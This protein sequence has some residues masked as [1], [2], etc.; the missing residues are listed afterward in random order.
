[1]KL[2]IELQNFS[3]IQLKAVEEIKKA[4]A[5]EDEGRDEAS[6]IKKP[7]IGWKWANCERDLN[8]LES[9]QGEFYNWK[10]LPYSI[11]NQGSKRN[12]INMNLHNIGQGF[13]KM[14]QTF[15]SDNLF[16]KDL[17]KSSIVTDEEVEAHDVPSSFKREFLS[18]NEEEIRRVS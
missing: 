5:K 6:L 16:N 13:S 8:N 3:K 7:L 11:R 15:S 4:Q 10:K 17:L 1:M 14:L 18:D 2:K 12:K 9:T